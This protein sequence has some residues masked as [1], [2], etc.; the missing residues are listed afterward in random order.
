MG[1]I[2]GPTKVRVRLRPSLTSS[3]EVAGNCLIPKIDYY[4]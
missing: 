2:M 1:E 3:F 4:G